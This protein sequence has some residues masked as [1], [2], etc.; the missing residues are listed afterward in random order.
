MNKADILF[1]SNISKIIN[2][3]CWDSG[4]RPMW[5]D[6]TPAS[7]RFITHVFETYDISKGE[8]PLISFRPVPWKSAIKEMLWIYQDQT[9]ELSILKEKH[10]IHWWD[11]WESKSIP[12]TIGHRYGYTIKKYDQVNRLIDGIKNNPYSRRHITTMWDWNDFAE[13]DGLLPCAFETQW[14]VRGEHLD[15]TLI[16]RSSDSGTALHTNQIQYVALLMMIA[17]ECGLKAGQFSHYINNYHIYDRHLDILKDFLDMSPAEESARLLYLGSGFYSS[18]IEHFDL[19]GYSPN[20]ERP[21]FEL[22]I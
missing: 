13:T 17:E 8:F 4:P 12:G 6:G 11:S 22:A 1:Q 7:S 18:G 3:G 14:S 2:E 15:M 21:F 20:P 9:S 19:V 10:N 5:A 16:Q